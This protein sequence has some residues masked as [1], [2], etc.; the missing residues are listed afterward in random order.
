MEMVE[1]A[2]ALRNREHKRMAGDGTLGQALDCDRVATL[3]GGEHIAVR[4]DR[5][6]AVYAYGTSSGRAGVREPVGKGN[7]ASARTAKGRTP[8]ETC[9]RTTADERQFRRLKTGE[10]PVCPQ[11]FLSP[12]FPAQHP[13]RG[14]VSPL[15][16]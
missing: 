1:R 11:V 16:P 9:G 2:A 5:A 8:Q 3:S 14:D 15:H 13:F 12:G 7:L 6:A 10:R 4:T